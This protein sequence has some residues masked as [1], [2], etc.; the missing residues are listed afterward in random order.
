MIPDSSA[1]GFALS[2]NG[3]RQPYLHTSEVVNARGEFNDV[4]WRLRDDT[5]PSNLCLFRPENVQVNSGVT[6]IVLRHEETPVR[7]YTS[8]AIAA[9]SRHTYG[10]YSAR[11]RPS[12]VPGLITGVFLHRDAPRQEIDLEFLGQDSR[13]MLVNVYY[14][15]GCDGTR[16]QYGYRG[17]P[18]LID[19]GFDASEDFHLYEI[20][21]EPD[22]IRWRVDE[23]LVHERYVWEPTPIPNL[24]AEFNLN[25]WHSR[26]T[27]LAGRLWGSAL[28]AR[29]Q[30][31][32]VRISV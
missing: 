28:P 16:L 19:L 10:R 30:F 32:D 6:E 7:E 11:V 20:E 24:P 8:G 27:E 29:A 22:V 12:A 15:P 2:A 23:R 4:E 18:T 26:S 1:V 3:I 25:L 14:N 13:H 5:F 21:W 17:T 31:Q 9:R